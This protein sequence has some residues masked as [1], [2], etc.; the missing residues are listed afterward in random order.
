[1]KKSLKGEKT[2]YLITLSVIFAMEM[3]LKGAT[4]GFNLTG[5]FWMEILLIFLISCAVAAV[6]YFFRTV[7]NDKK[8]KV[9][10]SVMMVALGF[11][12]GAQIVYNSVFGTYF[13]AYSLLH[14][15]GQA[16]E[17]FDVV[18]E[19]LWEEKLYVLLLILIAIPAIVL[20]C[21]K[22]TSIERTPQKYTRKF[23]ALICILIM[24]LSIS[25]SYIILS[26]E[27][28][29][30][31]SPYQKV[32]VIG[33]LKS[34]VECLG[35][36]G[37][38]SLDSWRAAFGF[39]PKLQEEENFVEVKKSDNVIDSLDFKAMADSEE[40][41]IIKNMHIY[42]GAQ[43]PT[44]ENDYTGM[45]EGKN[46]IFI[47]A[48]AF[49]DIAIDPVYTPTLYKLATEGYNFTNF[50]NPIWGTSTLDGEYVNMQGLVPKPGVWSMRESAENYLPFTLGNQ[51]SSLGYNTKAFH[52]HSIYFYDRDISHPN[53]GYE[54]KGQGREYL[55]TEMWPESDLE[56]I[57]QTTWEYLTPDEN[58][59]IAPFHTYYLTVSGHLAY[60]F[61]G[62]NIAMRNEAM[63]MNM[64]LSE[65]CKA[66]MATQIELDKALELLIYRL[67][68]AGAL[69]NT[70]IAIAGDHYPYGLSAEQISEFKGHK[71]DEEYEL[72]KN[73]FIVWSPGMEAREIDKLC[74]NMDILPTML[75]L[76]GI[77]YDSRLL[78]GKDILSTSDCLVVF[79]D[80]NWISSKGTR[81]QLEEHA[82]EYVR[83]VDKHVSN[84]FNYSA[85]ILDKDYY[86]IVFNRNKTE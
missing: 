52:N 60:N 63:V 67:G 73:A 38:V 78:M 11:G 71:V 2:V 9:V 49:S 81:S 33:E 51:F 40:D 13:T 5:Y 12:Y 54:F 25:T 75:N 82:L 32:Y 64:D 26:T 14:G 58:G 80:K 39:K 70:V 69:E 24:M 61:Y 79:K 85:L 46:L 72:Y 42:F 36:V 37:G 50:Y 16:F 74:S 22:K 68:E 55:F 59:K 65:A 34:S 31:K 3:V 21:K 77:D 76:F 30:P 17:F 23:V 27:N 66:Y 56:M 35:F 83:Q 20:V 6:P 15:T 10:Y 47:T 4:Q 48:E 8:A 53:L 28:D 41:E 7:L 29:D 1:M 57:E 62:N 44:K 84:M 86:S 18:L 43:K 19:N 45:F